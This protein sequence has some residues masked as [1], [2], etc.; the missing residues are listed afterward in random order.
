MKKS[1]LKILLIVAFVPTGLIA[2]D[3]TEAELEEAVDSN[4]FAVGFNLN[5][6]FPNHESADLYTGR[7][8]VSTFGIEHIFNQPQNRQDFDDYFRAPYQ[9][10]EYPF[11]P[12][13]RTGAELGLHL[14]YRLDSSFYLFFDANI[15]QL[16]F[17]QFFTVQVD[18]PTNQSVEP[19]LER[20]AIFGEENRINLNLGFQYNF[21]RGETS[22]AY[23]SAFGN[24]NDVEMQRNYF[25]INERRYNIFHLNN[26][27]PDLTPGGIGTGGGGGLGF[28]FKFNE[29]IWVDLNYHLCYTMINLTERFQDRALQNSL[30]IRVLWEI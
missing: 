17:E 15:I 26:D 5:A 21:Y 25:V 6:Y 2:Q 30:G 10:A 16:S 24:V 23:I 19:N 11:E 7:P 13:Y 4:R 20:F 8:D 28:K 3:Y 14:S 29:S 1:L 22:L 18:D 12:Q 27:S 9:I